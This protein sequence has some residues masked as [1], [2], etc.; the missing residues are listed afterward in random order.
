MDT[1]HA[2]TFVFVSTEKFYKQRITGLDCYVVSFFF[3]ISSSTIALRFSLTL[4]ND[5]YFNKTP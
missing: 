3:L 2:K 4:P 5:D 1:Y